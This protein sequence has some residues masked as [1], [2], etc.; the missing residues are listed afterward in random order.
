MKEKLSRSPSKFERSA[1]F[2]S[3]AGGRGGKVDF[4]AQQL[5]KERRNFFFAFLAPIEVVCTI[6]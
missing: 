5:E 3:I 4:A 6:T 2:R 1:R